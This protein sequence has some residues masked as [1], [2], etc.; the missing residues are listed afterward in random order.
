[1]EEKLL[2]EVCVGTTCFVLG[3]SALQSLEDFLPEEC[4]DKVEIVGAPCLGCCRNRNESGAPFV[5]VGNEIVSNATIQ[6][7]IEKIQA[8]LA[9]GSHA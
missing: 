8:V 5:R 9:G 2:V 7:V 1:M 4:R 3:A 6:N